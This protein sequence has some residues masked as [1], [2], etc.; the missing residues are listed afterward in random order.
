MQTYVTFTDFN[1]GNLLIYLY[2]MRLWPLT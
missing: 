1:K 2:T